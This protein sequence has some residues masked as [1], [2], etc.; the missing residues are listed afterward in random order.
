MF[1][2]SSVVPAVVGEYWWSLGLLDTM[3][4]ICIMLTVNVAVK[5]HF[6]I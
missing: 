6:R 1:G 4:V 2:L 3:N 5:R